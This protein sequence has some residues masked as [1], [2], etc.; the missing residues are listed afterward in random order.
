[1]QKNKVP[2]FHTDISVTREFKFML[3]KP[4]SNCE[5][6][7]K[8]NSEYYDLIKANGYA[9][10]QKLCMEQ[11]FQGKVLK[12]CGCTEAAYISLY[13]SEQMCD[14]NTTMFDCG[15]DILTKEFSNGQENESCEFKCPLECN[16]IEYKTTPSSYRLKGDLYKDFINENEI[17]SQDSNETLNADNAANSIVSFN[18]YYDS[19]SYLQTTESP[20]MNLVS[21]LASIGGN[22]SLLLGI[23]LFSLFEVIELLIEIYFIFYK[24]KKQILFSFTFPFFR[25]F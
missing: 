7:S 2:G 13:S 19:L 22:L 18:I 5:S 23:S 3:P 17:F 21:L 9:Y 15:W 14:S 10:S 16:L 6:E 25:K 20:K 8:I 12:E 11:C 1:M 24:A 4:Y